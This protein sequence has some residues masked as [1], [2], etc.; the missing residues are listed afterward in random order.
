[1]R[2]RLEIITQNILLF[3]ARIQLTIGD[4]RCHDGTIVGF[5]TT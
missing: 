1:M 4:F 3:V 2:E 5:T